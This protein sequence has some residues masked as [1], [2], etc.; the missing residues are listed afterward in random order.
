MRP[1]F[2]IDP[3]IGPEHYKTYQITA[4]KTTHFRKATCKEVECAGYVNGWKTIVP[5]RS[6]QASYI[7][8]ASGRKFTETKQPDQLVEFL[9]PPGQMC[10][11]ADDHRISL[12][13]EPFFVVRGGDYRGN[14]R[15]IEPVVRKVEDW[16]D[17]FAT[18]QQ[19][20]ADAIQRG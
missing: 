14:P 16:V 3:K 18:H 5:D 15:G 9:F 2:R 10:F 11:R 4:P 1:L 17:D 20:I 13:R 19:G 12:E 8:G 6:P 7:R